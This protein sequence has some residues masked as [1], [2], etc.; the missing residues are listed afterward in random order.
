VYLSSKHR[1]L[2]DVIQQAESGISERRS[3]SKQGG[4][5]IQIHSRIQRLNDAPWPDP[6]DPAL[7]PA[8]RCKLAAPSSPLFQVRLHQH[9]GSV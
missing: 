1:N 7:D 8:L 9:Q 4:L 5:V 6:P 3:R 2:R